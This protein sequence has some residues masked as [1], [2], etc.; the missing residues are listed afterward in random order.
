MI[1]HAEHGGA[2]VGLGVVGVGEFGGV[3]TQQVMEGVPAGSGF[4]DQMDISQFGQ[5][6]RHLVDRA[7]GDARGGGD[8]HVRAWVQT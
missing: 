7:T 4:G 1:N 3:G 5:Y 6:A 8:A 2:P